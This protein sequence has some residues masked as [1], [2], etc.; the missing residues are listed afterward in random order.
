M[1]AARGTLLILRLGS[2]GDTVV[3]LPCFHAIARAYPNYRRV[4]LTNQSVSTRTSSA[5]SVLGGSGLVD[6][7]AHY[8]V[9]G[10]DFGQARRLMTGIRRF[11]PAALIYLVERP[12]FAPLLRDWL[13]LKAAGVP[14]VIG[15]PWSRDL[16]NCRTDPSTGELEHEAYRVGRNLQRHMPIDFGPEN[17]GLRF[18]RAEIAAVD[19][20]IGQPSKREVLVAVAPGT[21]L[22]AKDWGRDRWAELLAS[23]ADDYRYARLVLLGAAEE[24]ALCADLALLWKGPV[25]N[26]CGGLTPRESAAAL[27]RCRILICHDSGPM[28]LAASQGTPCV[29]LFGNHNR[30]RRW[31]PFGENHRIIYEPRGIQEISVARVI[32]EIREALGTA[33]AG[34]ALR[35]AAGSQF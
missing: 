23:I 32:Q 31:F 33:P 29:A 22:A 10:L 9:G 24:R 14:K 28:H 19:R 21:K 2:I 1:M 5:L 34:H 15:L 26:A 27:S 3:A 13:F 7:V 4:L 35:P 12:R 11:R 6:E 30:P 17:W 25:S 18:S 16:R 20:L 8:P